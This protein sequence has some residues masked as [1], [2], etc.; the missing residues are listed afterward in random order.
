VIESDENSIQD[1]ITLVCNGVET[2]EGV[3]KD[4]VFA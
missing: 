1:E 4:T 2:D 3:A